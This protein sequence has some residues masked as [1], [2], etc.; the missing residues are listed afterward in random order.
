MQIMGRRWMWSQPLSVGGLASM[1]IGAGALALVGAMTDSSAPLWGRVA[2]ASFGVVSLCL[3]LLVVL[4]GVVVAGP[5]GVGG[6]R[7]WR[8]HRR[9]IPWDDIESFGTDRMWGSF[10]VVL[11]GGEFKP[12]AQVGSLWEHADGLVVLLLVAVFRPKGP[13][14]TNQRQ[15]RRLARRIAEVRYQHTG[16][17]GSRGIV[18]VKM[19]V[20]TG[21]HD[22]I[23][24]RP[25]YRETMVTEASKTP[26]LLPSERANAQAGTRRSRGKRR[27][28]RGQ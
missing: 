5:E 13:G 27:Q 19:P 20:R 14:A 9:W 17:A 7:T 4:A 12:L 28:R 15:A 16:H 25:T 23:A 1:F 10:G 18:V 24:G 22:S 11:K 8:G 6:Y 21:Q 2:F 3:A 26:Y